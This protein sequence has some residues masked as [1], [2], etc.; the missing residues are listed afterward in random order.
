MDNER[1]INLRF[2]SGTYDELDQKRHRDETTFQHVGASLFVSWLRGGNAAVLPYDLSEEESQMVK[3]LLNFLRQ[4][5]HHGMRAVLDSVLHLHVE[6]KKS[7]S[8]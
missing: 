4:N 2:D 3:A 7:S 6:E 1:R 5:R 8:G